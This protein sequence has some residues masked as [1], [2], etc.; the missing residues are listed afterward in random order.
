MYIL[1]LIGR[2][3]TECHD[4]S[5][6]LFK[7]GKIIVAVEQE[8]FSR[9]KHA[10]GEGPIDA[11]LYCLR[12]AGI[13]IEDVDYI[14]Y[15]WL[16]NE[17][18]ESN[19]E[20][21]SENI[22]KSSILTEELLPKEV[23][24]YREPPPIYF[25]KHHI[26]HINAAFWD[27]GFKD[28]ACLIIDGQGESESITLAEI[29]NGKINIIRQFSIPYSLG[30]FYDAATEYSGL[31]ENVP[32]K[33]MGLSAYGKPYKLTSIL[34]DDEIGE[35]TNHPFEEYFNFS[36][37]EVYNKW[38]R[39]FEENYYPYKK[40]DGENIMYYLN[41][42]ATIQHTLTSVILSLLKYLKTQ[43]FSEN[44]II[45]GGVGLNCIT[46]SAIY[47]SKIFKNIFIHPATNDAS[48]SIGSIYEVCRFLGIR[49]NKIYEFRPFLGPRY[50]NDEIEKIL[51]KYDI[52]AI[53]MEEDQLIET[54]AEDLTENKIVAWFQ[55]RME[56]GPRALGNRSILG[57]P[58]YQENLY[59]INK[60]KGR[61]I[62]RPLAPS[63]LEEHFD[64]IFEDG[65]SKDLCKY[66]LTTVKIKKERVKKI[67]AVVHIDGTT[68]L[69]IVNKKQKMYYK[70]INSFYN[71]TG[72]PLIINTSFNLAGEPIVNTPEE[73]IKVFITNEDIDVL[74]MENIYL[75]RE[76]EK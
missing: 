24:R 69:Q 75:K 73:A 5:A 23:F 30:I 54:V 53:Y 57:N 29:I 71:K 70:L 4:A 42:S 76:V 20:V 46:N 52:G 48:C 63:V 45:A 74:V 12:Y 51:R 31:G 47:K 14:T 49:I 7:D 55:G 26:A 65:C 58:Y 15:G 56:L 39:Y 18:R 32:G 9:R 66:M 1:G 50:T 28:A 25:V 72:I 59:K 2:P 10:K 67:P 11:A 6:A 44:L 3:G 41:F 19:G 34:F 27:S 43:A 36:A 37:K 13:S 33:F 38:I 8:R 22:I 16:E 62:W 17:V 64:E 35:F 60:I 68:R 21:L 40:G 61:V